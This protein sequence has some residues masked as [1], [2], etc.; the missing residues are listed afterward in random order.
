MS[1]VGTEKTLIIA[2]GEYGLNKYVECNDRIFIY[3]LPDS[4]L[5]AY[6]PSG[7]GTDSILY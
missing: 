6:D 5:Q 3:A 2:C 4:M 7:E 1:M